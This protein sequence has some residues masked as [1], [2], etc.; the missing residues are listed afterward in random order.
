MSTQR[1]TA[2][3]I[4]LRPATWDD[5]EF[6]YHVLKTTMREH[7]ERIWH[8]D[9]QWQREYFGQN[10]NP[11]ENQII[12]LYGK[13]IGVF[14]TRRQ[15]DEIFLARIYIL[16]GYQNQGIGTQLLASLLAEAAHQG[17]EVT[18]RVLKGNPARRLYERMGFVTVEE[19]GTHYSM[20]ATTKREQ[21]GLR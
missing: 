8:W 6:L 19:S 7:V 16:P 17:L 3:Q 9:D 13:D 12:V 10:F 2:Q 5:F 11:D 21:K 20:K 15:D 1:E 4:T 14:G 18:L